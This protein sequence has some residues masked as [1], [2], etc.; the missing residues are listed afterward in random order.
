M[1]INALRAFLQQLPEQVDQAAAQLKAAAREVEAN[2]ERL[3][4]FL[5][6]QSGGSP[7]DFTKQDNTEAPMSTEQKIQWL[8][9]NVS[10]L[11]L[12]FVNKLDA[13]MVNEVYKYWLSRKK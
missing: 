3:E 4:G 9:D 11:N 8:K 1:D 7:W 10:N 12:D 13:D 6:K 2:L 5:P